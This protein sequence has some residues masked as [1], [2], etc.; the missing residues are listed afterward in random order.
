[1]ITPAD[2][3]RVLDLVPTK[4]YING[5]WVD[6]EAGKTLDVL[7]PATGFGLG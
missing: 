7:D 1:M 3:K 4:L 6:A 2:E 5:Q